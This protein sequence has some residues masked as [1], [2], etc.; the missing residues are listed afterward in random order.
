MLYDPAMSLTLEWLRANTWLLTILGA[1]VAATIAI[2]VYRKNASPK[3]VDYQVVDEFSMLV[4]KDK[5]KPNGLAVTYGGRVIENPRVAIIQ[6]KNNG[7]S[8]ISESD[9]RQ[10]I[11]VEL[12]GKRA[13]HATITQESAQNLVLS[14]SD[15]G[16]SKSSP[17]E[18]FPHYWNPR[19]SFT[20]RF[21]FDSQPG[22]L[23]VSCRFKD[24]SR[25]MRNLRKID[26]ERFLPPLL[27]LAV[28]VVA[29]LG[30]LLS[31]LL[32]V[33]VFL[34]DKLILLN[35]EFNEP[36]YGAIR[37]WSKLATHLYSL[38]AISLAAIVVGM[39]VR[40]KIQ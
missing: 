7:R 2:T 30:V 21:L 23:A 9:Y 11:V 22:D 25:P 1:V 16:S 4:A 19:E 24:Q 28:F 12:D 5:I 20:M 10:G 17:A 14:E 18:I 40:K 26:S 32:D 29:A 6:F 31:L 36:A 15:D 3:T 33:H 13:V 8:T 35:P 34:I 27:K 38:A 37:T 39:W